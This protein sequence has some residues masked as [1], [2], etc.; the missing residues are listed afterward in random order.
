MAIKIA[1]VI[2]V[3]KEN[4]NSLKIKLKIYA[5]R[6]TNSPSPIEPM[7]FPNAGSKTKS[8]NKIATT[9][10]TRANKKT[11]AQELPSSIL[12]VKIE[13]EKKMKNLKIKA[14]L[15]RLIYSHPFLRD[16]IYFNHL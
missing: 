6:P 5:N 14:R 16:W 9:V 8:P 7:M 13:N 15:V 11:N 10:L 2:M 4:L 3:D 12:K 1:N